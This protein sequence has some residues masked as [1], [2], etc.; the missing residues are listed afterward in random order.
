MP[1]H[2]FEITTAV[3]NTGVTM[4]AQ[5]NAALQA[6]ASLSSGT[7][8]P[9]TPYVYQLWADTTNDLLKMRDSTNTSWITVG[10]LSSIYLG[11]ASLEAENEF[12][13]TQKL[14]GDAL[15]LRLKDSG[16]SGEEWAIR[17]DG[18]NFEIV[19]NTGTEG[20]P[21]WTVQARVDVNALRLGD[22]TA[23]DIRLIANNS[24]VTKPE[25]RYQNSSSQW[26]VSN[27]GEAFSAVASMPT[28]SLIAFPGATEPAGYLECDGSPISRT[29]YASLYGVI[30]TMFGVGDGTTTFN[31]PD[32]RGRFLRGWDH[33][34]GVDPDAASRTDR[35]DGTTGDYVGTREDDAFKSHHHEL[36]RPSSPILSTAAAQ[37]H[38]ALGTA[39]VQSGVNTVDTGGN[40][41]R[42]VN[43]AVMYCIKY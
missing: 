26:Q 28:G 39:Q 6:L 37:A 2:H 29:T 8:E 15:L 17:S 9:T 43:I 10:R 12:T 14:A 24:A 34:A 3:A 33:G 19:K 5:I 31:L 11:L 30:G 13:V 42:P 21:T 16:T 36:Y 41:T 20:T 25:I 22:G 7:S 1:Q 4:R 18:G 27:D 32:L 35:G 23:S 38:Y 40:E